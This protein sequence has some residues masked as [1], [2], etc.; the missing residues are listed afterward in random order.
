MAVAMQARRAAFAEINTTPLVD[1]MLVLLVVFMLAAPLI[2]HQ[3]DF[4]VPI[5][6][7]EQLAPS[8][9]LKIELERVH[10][11]SSI[12]V[13]GQEMD[14]YRFNDWLRQGHR[15]PSKGFVLSGPETLD[16]QQVS[17]VMAVLQKHGWQR[18]SFE[19]LSG[20]AP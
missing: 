5:R 12:R 19:K 10:G 9:P 20:A 8:T 3:M 7:K 1:V 18:G 17:R 2:P 16:Y 15:D 14:L 11:Q 6:S 4:K 13:D